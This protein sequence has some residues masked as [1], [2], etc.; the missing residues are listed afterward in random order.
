MAAASP[1]N[2]PLILLVI[3]AAAV[4]FT[5]IY[6]LKKLGPEL[7]KLFSKTPATPPPTTPPSTTPP[8]AG[9]GGG[10]E[11]EE[12]GGEEEEEGG[13]EEEEGGGDADS[14]RVRSYY[15]VQTPE[16]STYDRIPAGWF[17]Y[18]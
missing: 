4:H 12:E 18:S 17:N 10:G 8:P 1:L 14:D 9:G 7:K 13:E 5:G 2:S 16:F 15:L 6:D 3:A 11:E